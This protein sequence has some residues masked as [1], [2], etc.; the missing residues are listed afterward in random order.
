MQIFDWLRTHF[1]TLNVESTENTNLRTWFNENEVPCNID[2]AFERVYDCWISDQIHENDKND[3][4]NSA[5]GFININTFILNQGM[6]TIL[7]TTSIPY[8]PV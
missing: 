3:E 1:Y 8:K 4:G 5:A 2:G 7:I 6:V